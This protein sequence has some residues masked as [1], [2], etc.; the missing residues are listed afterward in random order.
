MGIHRVA[1]VWLVSLSL[2]RC[3]VCVRAQQDTA[4][5]PSPPAPAVS[6]FAHGGFGAHTH[7]HICAISHAVHARV[8]RVV[9]GARATRA[10]KTNKLIKINQVVLCTSVCASVSLGCV[11][12]YVC[13]CVCKLPGGCTRGCVQTRAHARARNARRE[14]R[15]RRRHSARVACNMNACVPVR[16]IRKETLIDL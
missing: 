15:R 16:P 12:L 6:S 5:T 7:T 9:P 10:W 4:P 2:C 13:V 14:N 11:R 3:G 8:A 1:C